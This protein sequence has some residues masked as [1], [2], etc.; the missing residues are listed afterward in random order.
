MI[1][2]E[3]GKNKD[4][5]SV[6]GFG[7]GYHAPKDGDYESLEK[8]IHKA[9]DVGINFIDTAPVYGS[10]M[11]EEVLGQILKNVNRSDVFLAS[12]ISPENTTFSGVISSIE[13]S[14]SRLK[15]DRIDLCQIH[16]PS[17]KVPI[18][19]TMSA[20]EKMVEEGKIRN[21]GVSNF[22][23]DEASGALSALRRNRLVSIQ[24]EFN[25]FERSVENDIL[26][27]CKEN[28]LILIAYSPLAQGKIVNG[29]EQIEFIDKLA[30]KYNSS[31]AQIA[32]RWLVSNPDVIVIPNTSKPHRATENGLSASIQLSVSDIA[33]ISRKLKTEVRMINT[34]DIR[35]SNDHGRKVYQTI[36]EAIDNKMG[37]S[38]SPLELSNQMKDGVFLK[39]IRIKEL[40]TCTGEKKYDLIEGRLR[41]WAWIIA[42]GPDKHIP[43]LV[44]RK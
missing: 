18:E 8:S 19:E 9:I 41:Y 43:S 20:M 10:G 25:F 6:I 3:I 29:R 12:K 15:T 17:T 36:Q 4:R 39:S 5:V 16:W 23:V 42:H 14:L 44:W 27:F 30:R 24:S 26:P 22:S 13:S 32:L 7:T 11:S 33:S 37:M 38:P 31:P 2:R 34:S 21:I 28:N 35:V 40:D 1:Y